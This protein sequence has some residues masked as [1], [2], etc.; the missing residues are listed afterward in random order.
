MIPCFYL[1]DMDGTLT[2]ARLPMT[3]CFAVFFIEFIKKNKVYIVSGSDIEKIK[4]Q[5]PKDIINGVEGIYASMG[6]ELY[7]KGKRIYAKK[8]SPPQ[9][10]TE[11]LEGYRK[12]TKYEG[13]LYSNYIEYRCG[14]INFSVL[15]RDCPYE[16][17]V[18]YKQWDDIYGERK[19]VQ[20]QL[21][22]L[23]PSLDITLGGNI[24]LD[25]TPKGFGKEQ[26]ADHLRSIYPHAK[27]IFAG[28]KTEAGGNDYALA[29]RL[30]QLGNCKII[31]VNG[32]EDVIEKLS[33]GE[34]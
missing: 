2:P 10:L 13:M 21:T 3:D 31:A 17:R 23:F 26:V 7:K 28:D 27:I 32:P 1:F 20:R 24:S 30:K 22:P 33:A 11:L 14:M 19:A 25:I 9:G 6:N 4:S 18:K 29:Q 15:G 5:M 8:F 12:S 34:I 16:E